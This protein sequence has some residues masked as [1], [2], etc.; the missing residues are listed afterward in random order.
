MLDQ[1]PHRRRKGLALIPFAKW[2]ISRTGKPG[3]I[4]VW[5]GQQLHFRFYTSSINH[6]YHVLLTAQKELDIDF[7]IDGV[8]L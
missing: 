2:D 8:K 6:L 4:N 1:G 5:A 7:G 3:D